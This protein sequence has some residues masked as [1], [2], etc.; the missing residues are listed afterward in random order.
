MSANQWKSTSYG[1]T[2]KASSYNRQHSRVGQ[3]EVARHNLTNGGFRKNKQV[4]NHYLAV[5]R[6]AHPGTLVHSIGAL[7]SKCWAEGLVS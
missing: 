6:A 2:N 7:V 1:T 3:R 4:Y 5:Y